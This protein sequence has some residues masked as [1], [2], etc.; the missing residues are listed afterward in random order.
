[1]SACSPSR[2]KTRSSGASASAAGTSTS[3]ASRGRLEA[4]ARRLTAAVV[5]WAFAEARRRGLEGIRL[6]TWADNERLA[7][8]YERAGFVRVGRTAIP[9][10]AP[11]LPHYAGIEV[12]LLEAP[13]R[14]PTPPKRMDAPV[15]E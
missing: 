4:E 3:T 2:T 11:L 7:A 10:G 15:G 12:V 1:M 8:H 14:D 5:A 13:L 9:S 6:D